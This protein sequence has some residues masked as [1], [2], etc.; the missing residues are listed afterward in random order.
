MR[1]AVLVGG[2]LKCTLRSAER[3]MAGVCSGNYIGCGTSCTGLVEHKEENHAALGSLV[4][5]YYLLLVR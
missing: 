5:C 2:L 1:P 3:T 4:P